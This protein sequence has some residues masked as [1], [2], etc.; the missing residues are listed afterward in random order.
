MVV[1]NTFGA[2]E[3]KWQSVASVSKVMANVE[4]I[5]ANYGKHR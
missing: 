2:P 1:V 5:G 4:V 3:E